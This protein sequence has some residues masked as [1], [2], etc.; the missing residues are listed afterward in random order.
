MPP[1]DPPSAST[2]WRRSVGGLA[3]LGFVALI[4][5]RLTGKPFLLVLLGLLFGVFF[6]GGV[7][8]VWLVRWALRQESR[9]GQF[10]IASLLLVTAFAAAFF[11][12]VR[13]L[14][15]NVDDRQVP[16]RFGPVY[17]AI[18]CVFL[19]GIGI[20]VVLYL[21]EAFVWLAA[22]LVRRPAVQRWLA[23]RRRRSERR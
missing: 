1:F 8:L 15:T 10:S 17:V 5:S 7:A 4:L 16:G 12:A 18:V 3:Y 23:R 13:W 20:P 11:G 19:A 9:V 21:V 2:L 6:S 14:V 22:W